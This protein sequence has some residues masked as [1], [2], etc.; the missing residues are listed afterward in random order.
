MSTITWNDEKRRLGDL[1]EWEQNPKQM[2]IEDAQGLEISLRKFGFA[3]PL[4]VGPDNS[5]YDGHQRKHLLEAVKEY[6]PDAV[7]PVRVSSRLLTANERKEFVI[8]LKEAQ[9]DWD[10]EALANVYEPGELKAWGMSEERLAAAFAGF[11]SDGDGSGSSG[12]GDDEDEETMPSDGS[13]LALVNITIDEP[14]HAVETGDIWQLGE[15]VLVVA[16]VVA[17]WPAWVPFLEQGSLLAPYPG[18]FA[19]LTLKAEGAKLVMIQPDRYIA[20]HILDR[21][22]DVKGSKEIRRYAD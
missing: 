4:L 7:V 2:S 21:Y 13:L 9:A 19:P 3:Y 5:L 15:H 11:G 14:R 16:D 6:G 20:G 1:I 12:D 17:D 10:W 22:E 18:P 8:R